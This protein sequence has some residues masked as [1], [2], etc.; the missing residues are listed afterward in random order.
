MKEFKSIVKS[1]GF[2]GKVLARGFVR[3]AYGA[4]T[5]GLLGMAA[6][7]Y[8][9]ITGES[10]WTAVC[11]FVGSTATLCMGLMWMYVIGCNKRG[12]KK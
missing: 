3:M 7:G 1:I 8:W 5:A 9:M 4:G 12:A 10:G 11:E 6:Y 2:H